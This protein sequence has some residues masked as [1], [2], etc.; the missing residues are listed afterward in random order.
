MEIIICLYGARLD[1][2]MF[3][4]VTVR[5]SHFV[6]NNEGWQIATYLCHIIK[7]NGSC[8]ENKTND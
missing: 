7:Q 4:V 3:L 6:L 1:H 2:H 8:F 5:L